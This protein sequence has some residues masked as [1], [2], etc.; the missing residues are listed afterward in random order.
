L[1]T[2]SLSSQHF[3][4]ILLVKLSALGDVVHTI[5]LLPKL[6]ARFP[7]A[8]AGRERVVKLFTWEHFRERVL[9][10][11]RLARS[12]AWSKSARAR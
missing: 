4:R 5:P 12:K 10:A 8:A 6:R 7:S 1:K 9:G 11:Y 2:E 3:S